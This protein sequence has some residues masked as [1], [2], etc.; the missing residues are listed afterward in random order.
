MDLEAARRDGVM[1][2]DQCGPGEFSIEDVLP[3]DKEQHIDS[4]TP[5]IVAYFS[6]KYTTLARSIS[7]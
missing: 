6:D 2:Y 3:V 5:R 7:V 4:R 1:L